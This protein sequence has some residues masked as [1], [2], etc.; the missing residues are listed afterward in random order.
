MK[1]KEKIIKHATKMF[2]HEG[3]EAFSMRKLAKKT[4]IA[5]SV[6]YHYF[7]GKNALLKKMFRHVSIQL[8][9]KRNQLP[10][11]K[12]ASQM[13][14]TR[15]EFQIDHAEEV[16]AVLKFF[17]AYRHLFPKIKTGY[18]PDKAYQHIEEVLQRG[19]AT[20]EFIDLDIKKEAK[21]ITH[22]INGF[23]LEYYPKTPTQ[24]EKQELIS[25]IHRFI[26]RSIKKNQ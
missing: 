10:K 13:L 19:K 8:G 5:Q 20:N 25:T 14:K 26:I 3:Y 15:I 22:A 4:K 11:A 23:L 21:V 9:K 17:L 24:K 18:I 12:T 6:I 16:V 1:T 7:A 2:A